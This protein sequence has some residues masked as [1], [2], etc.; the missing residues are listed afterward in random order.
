ITGYLV[1]L[2][3]DYD[4]NSGRK[5]PMVLF[6]H[7]AGEVGSNLNFIKRN[8]PPRMVNQGKEFPFILV[9]PQARYTWDHNGPAIDQFVEEMKK[10][11]KVDNNRFYV[12]GLSMGGAA[13]WNYTTDYAHKV[14][15][16]VPI[17]GWGNP[18]RACEM[19]NV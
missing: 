11:Y 2:P 12:T 6:L 14:A 18:S 13:T 3:E 9:S 17:C 15:A 4:P 5:Y 1:Y 10:N 16:S 19:K 7:G 8:G